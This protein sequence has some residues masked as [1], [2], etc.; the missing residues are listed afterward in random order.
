M[1]ERKVC[2][3]SLVGDCSKCTCFSTEETK[4]ASTKKKPNK[5]NEA[6]CDCEDLQGKI[7]EMFKE[8]AKKDID[9]EPLDTAYALNEGDSNKVFGTK[10]MRLAE[11]LDKLTQAMLILGALDDAE[12]IKRLEEERVYDG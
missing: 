8:E 2:E 3:G 4:M 11:A 6:R 12:E 9:N 7:M 10:T 5:L 1:G